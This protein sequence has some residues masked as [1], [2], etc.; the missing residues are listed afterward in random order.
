MPE[1]FKAK[2][3]MK[4]I[5]VKSGKVAYMITGVSGD[6]VQYRLVTDSGDPFGMEYPLRASEIGE[7]L[8][9]GIVILAEEPPSRPLFD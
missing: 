4:F 2:V 7:D 3:G 5:N 1:E 9:S 6:W 8:E